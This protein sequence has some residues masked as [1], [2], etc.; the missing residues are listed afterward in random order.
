MITNILLS[1]QE[2]LCSPV[3]I[4]DRNLVFPNDIL[5]LLFKEYHRFMD[6]FSIGPIVAAPE[7]V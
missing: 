7:V 3:G 1:H 6:T 2:E 5:S 4:E